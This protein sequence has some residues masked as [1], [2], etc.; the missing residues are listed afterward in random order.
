MKEKARRF[1]AYPP[2][3]S[4][5]LFRCSRTIVAYHQF[6]I[7]LQKFT[8]SVCVIFGICVVVTEKHINNDREAAI[9]PTC[10]FDRYLI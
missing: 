6:T 9:D 3:Y 10:D 4:T 1:M 8:S 7:I 2:K 5:R